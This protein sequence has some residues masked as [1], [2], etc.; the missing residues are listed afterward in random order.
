MLCNVQKEGYMKNKNLKV[1]IVV[2]V[3]ISTLF[4]DKFTAGADESQLILNEGSVWRGWITWMPAL[5]R[6]KEGNLVRASLWMPLTESSPLPSSDWKNPDFDDSGWFYWRE[7]RAPLQMIKLK[8]SDTQIPVYDR[9]QYGIQRSIYMGL[10][11]FR[12]KFYV[13]NPAVVTSLSLTVKFRG[14]I[15]AYLNGH[16][17][18]RAFLPKEGGVAMDAPADD[19][20]EEAECAGVRYDSR[21]SECIRRL[22]TRIREFQINVSP[23]FLCKGVNVL[24]LEIHR[25]PLRKEHWNA[26]G[27]VSVELKGNGSGI[28]PNIKRPHGIQVWNANV[29]ERV[30]PF[31]AMACGRVWQGGTVFIQTFPLSWGI[32]WDLL[33]PL[34]IT[35]A[36]NGIFTAQIVVSS[37]EPIR[38]LNVTVEKLVHE[39]GKIYIPVDCV[40]IYYQGFPPAYPSSLRNDPNLSLLDALYDKCPPEVQIFKAWDGTGA[41]SGGEYSLGGT[42]IDEGAVVPIWI[43][44]KTPSNLPSGKYQGTLTIQAQGMKPVRVPVAVEIADFTLPE[45]PQFTTHVGTMICPNAQALYYKVPSWSD[46]H[47]KLLEKVFAYAFE[48]GGKLIYIPLVVKATWLSNDR[49]FVYWVKQPDGTYKYDF[50]LFDRYMTLVRKYLKPEVICLYVSDGAGMS[51]IK[52]VTLLDNSSGKMDILSLPPYQPLPESIQFWKPLLSEVKQRLAQFKL[53]DIAMLGMLWEGAGGGEAGNKLKA[54][55]DLFKE[56]APDMKWVQIAHYGGAGGNVYGVPYGYVMSVWGNNTPYKSKEFGARDLPIKVAWHPRAD[57]LTDIRPF[58]PRGAFRYVLHRSLEMGSMG[59]APIGLDFWNIPG[60][61]NLEGA[62]AW[63]LSMTEF[64][65]SALL[66]PGESGPIS[67]VRFEVFREGLQ[68]CEAYHVVKRALDNNDSRTKLG[69]ALEKKSREILAEINKYRDFAGRGEWSAEGEGWKWY[70]STDWETRTLK[71]YTC[72][73]EVMRVLNEKK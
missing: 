27:L 62:G 1:L 46:E 32:P 40:R 48:L 17:I 13:S 49:S 31:G 55:I 10:R 73:G 12:G 70:T 65:T 61:G 11:C 64:T 47:F 2:M 9:G 41:K 4:V 63:N 15:V 58:A 68:E 28:I 29:L 33:K 71:L 16:E 60:A 19:Y 72:A 44:I 56:A 14:G 53:D 3:I 59:V 67:T 57:A 39:T 6:N 54:V 43:K 8:E 34:R 36:K 5:T 66:A 7:A 24:A 20:P 26:C 30:T 37:D 52:G 21:D 35:G 22:N 50:S 18:G 23:K 51:Q 38:G 45:P 69:E 42:W 25:S